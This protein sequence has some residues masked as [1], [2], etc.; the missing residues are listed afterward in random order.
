MR[1]LHKNQNRYGKRKM[2]NG[3]GGSVRKTVE[4]RR[5][6]E[7]F[8]VVDRAINAQFTWQESV[9]RNWNNLLGNESGRKQNLY[10][11]ATTQ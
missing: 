7:K 1:A 2:Q 8:F 10:Y 11:Y 5:E 3:G 4:G 9:N 6:R